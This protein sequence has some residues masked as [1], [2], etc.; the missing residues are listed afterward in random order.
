MWSGIRSRSLLAVLLLAG[1]ASSTGG[2][3]DVFDNRPVLRDC[4]ATVLAQGDP[5]E[6]PDAVRDCLAQQGGGEAML[7]TPTDEGDPIQ[8]WYRVGPGIEGV[9]Y[10]TDNTQDS[11]GDRVWTYTSCPAATVDDLRQPNLMECE[12]TSRLVEG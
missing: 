9:E 1:C 4:G 3:S 7:E 5:I 2:S 6:L 12:Y 8:R 11:N 10:Y